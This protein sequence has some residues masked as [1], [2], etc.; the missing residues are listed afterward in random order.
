MHSMPMNGRPNSLPP[1]S[2]RDAESGI[3]PETC[4]GRIGIRP[5]FPVLEARRMPVPSAQHETRRRHRPPA[6]TILGSP[7]VCVGPPGPIG[8]ESDGIAT[9]ARRQTEQAARRQPA[10]GRLLCALCRTNVSGPSRVAAGLRCAPCPRSAFGRPLTALG[11]LLAKRRV[12]R[13]SEAPSK[14]LRTRSGA[15]RGWRNRPTGS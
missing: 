5:E 15:P 2:A 11:G 12:R 10:D 1:R 7:R 13:R 8:P 14:P 4:G 3:Q 9:D 6:L